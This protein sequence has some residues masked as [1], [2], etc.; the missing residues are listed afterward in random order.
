[1]TTG[2][3]RDLQMMAI[4]KC[5]IP[6]KVKIFMWMAMHDR[7]QSKVQLKKKKWSGPL[8]Y[9]V[10]GKVETADHILF[11]CPVAVF[12]WSFLRDTL[13]WSKSPTSCA[14]FLCEIVRD[15]RGINKKIN[16]FLC[17][18]ALWTIWK[19][20]NDVVFNK[21]V[22]SSPSVLIFKTLTLVKSWCPLL[23]PKLS[24]RADEVINLLTARAA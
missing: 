23:K 24:E 18:G 11:Q 10:C 4:W 2:G 3:I 13:G 12:L 22:V 8:E 19:T 7:I 5:N 16:I 6:L 15:G 14:D 20:R 17:A 1:M 9:L 21:K